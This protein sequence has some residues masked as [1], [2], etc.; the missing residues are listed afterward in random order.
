MGIEKHLAE[1]VHYARCLSG[2]A[3]IGH[4]RGVRAARNAKVQA[5]ALVPESSHRQTAA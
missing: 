2:K 1:A 3:G 5:L 4:A